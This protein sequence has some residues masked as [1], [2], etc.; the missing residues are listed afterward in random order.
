MLSNVVV[1]SILPVRKPAPNG[2][3]GTK[4]I[5]S[6]SSVG[7]ISASGL[8]LPQRIL[9]L[10]RRHRLNGVRPA[11]RL[12]P[13]LRQ[14]EVLDLACLD[15]VLDRAG[16]VLDRHLRIDAM[17]VEQID[18][19]VLS[20]LSEASA[21][22]LMCSGRL[23]SPAA[24]LAGRQIDVEAELGRD[25]HLVTDGRERLA[26]QFLVGERAI[27]LGGIEEGDAALDGRRMSAIISCLSA[28]G[29]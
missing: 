12:R 1:A 27:D 29:P 14:S 8:A 13:G 24:A 20:R 5:P 7:R 23:L 22:A 21:T 16:D 4:P 18:R 6:S 15:Q 28:G 25:H 2:L 9:A 19:S 3:N 17:L 11:D 10:D 26:D